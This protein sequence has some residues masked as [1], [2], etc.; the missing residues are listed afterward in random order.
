MSR[1]NDLPQLGIQKS[2]RLALGHEGHAPVVLNTT[3]TLK[4]TFQVVDKISSSGV[5]PHQTFLRFYDATTSEEGIQPIR[6][7][8]SGKG[9]FELTM[10]RPP[11]TFPPTLQGVPLQVSLYLGKQEFTPVAVELFEL[12][13]PESLPPS[14]HPDEG[15]FHALPEIEHTFAPDH[16]SPRKLVSGVFSGLVV[17]PW[18]VLLGLVGVLSCL[19]T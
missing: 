4:F 19:L 16:P 17:A 15:S 6:V 5:Q 8:P 3:D 12:Y 9:K 10:S 13:V 1:S 14:V 2:N 11:V 7:T 18:A